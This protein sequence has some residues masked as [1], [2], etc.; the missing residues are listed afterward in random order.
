MK[1]VMIMNCL[2]RLNDIMPDG[3]I[4]SGIFTAMN[5]LQS[6]PFN[7]SPVLMD[8]EYYGNISGGKIVSPLIDRIVAGNE[9]SAT[10]I[11]KLSNIIIAMYYER[12]GK[13]YDTMLLEYNPIQ[14]YDMVEQMTDDE[15]VHEYGKTLQRTDNLIHTKTGNDTETNNLQEQRTDNLSDQR[16]DNLSKSVDREVIETNNL[17][18]QRTDNL[19][20]QRTDN[21]SK[22]VDRDVTE[23]HNTTDTET[24]NLTNN[25]DNKIFGFNSSIG[26]DSDSQTVTATGSTSKTKTGTVGTVT[27]ETE[28]NT[29]TQTTLHTG[30]STN[31]KTGTVQLTHNTTDSDTGTQNTVSGGSDTSTRNY[32]LRRSGNIGVTTSQ[33]M[34]QAERDLWLWNFF[35]SVVFPD[36]DKVLTIPIY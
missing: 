13:L 7:V 4:G 19:S 12:W 2:K 15:T 20:D 14:N 18:E 10:E 33:Q 16:T 21:L 36:V 3:I 5:T 8:I 1:G 28:T 31:A 23:T 24:P 6:L 26:V 29:G 34:I 30:T 11:Q 17:Q 22:S 9:I 32:T 25:T 35:H 27:D